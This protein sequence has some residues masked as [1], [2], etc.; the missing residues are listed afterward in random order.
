M[1]PGPSVRLSA[2]KQALPTPA[3]SVSRVPFNL[4]SL[5]LL[6]ARPASFTKQFKFR[7]AT[8]ER[9]QAVN[10]VKRAKANQCYLVSQVIQLADDITRIAPVR[11]I[12]LEPAND[13]LSKFYQRLGFN[14]LDRTDWLFSVVP[15]PPAFCKVT[16][17]NDGSK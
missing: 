10:A 3:L 12:G 16:A 7:D 17:F 9:D 8:D 11:Y 5:P 4:E 1:L 14:K 2:K 15:K 13:R 6:S